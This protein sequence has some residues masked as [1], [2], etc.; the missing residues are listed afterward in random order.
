[1]S[2]KLLTVEESAER[3]RLSRSTIYKWIS[4]Q[5]KGDNT[6]RLKI[7]KLGS[8]VLISESEIER[9]IKEGQR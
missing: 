2:G 8:R 1:M 4:H 6:P 7:I 9:L 3:L 5:G